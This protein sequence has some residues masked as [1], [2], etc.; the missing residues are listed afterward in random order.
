MWWDDICSAFWWH[1]TTERLSLKEILE[2]DRNS[3]NDLTKDERVIIDT[4]FETLSKIFLLDD[5]RTRDPLYMGLDIHVIRMR[6]H[7]CNLS[8]IRT[9]RTAHLKSSI[10]WRSAVMELCNE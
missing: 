5:E 2:R 6:R 8:L 7:S 9:V 3:I 1:A 4:I 10:G